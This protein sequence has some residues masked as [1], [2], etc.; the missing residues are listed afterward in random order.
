VISEVTHRLVDGYFHTRSLGAVSL[1]GKAEAIRAWEV[2]S[3]RVARTRLVVEAERGLTPFVGRELELRLLTECFEKAK[4]GHGQVVF[5]VGEP[6]IGKS[7]LL[8]EFRRCLGEE[9]TW[10]E[11]QCLPFGGAIAFHPLIDLLKRNFRIEEGDTEL[12]IVGKIERGVLLLGQDLRSILPSVRYFLS[13]DP[14]R[15]PPP[16]GSGCGGAAASRCL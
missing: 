3:A 9:A 10:L 4:A 1:K 16:A 6:G 8:L 11:G 14:R 7:R 12:A 2:I 5:L 13:V 15:P